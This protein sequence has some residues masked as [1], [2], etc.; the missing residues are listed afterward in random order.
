MISDA[1]ELHQ[2]TYTVKARINIV[3]NG[4]KEVPVLYE[5]IQ[6]ANV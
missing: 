4:I 1:D 2:C 3:L 6:I 5:R